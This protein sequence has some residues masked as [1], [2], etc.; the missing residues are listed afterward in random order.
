MQSQITY[1]KLQGTRKKAAVSDFKAGQ[2]LSKV[3]K[4]M[5]AVNLDSR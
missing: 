3:R 4:T 1:N 5:N 2:N